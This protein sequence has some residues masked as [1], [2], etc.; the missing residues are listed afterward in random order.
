MFSMDFFCSAGVD[1]D[2]SRHTTTSVSTQAQRHGRHQV[3][4]DERARARSAGVERAGLIDAVLKGAERSRALSN[5]FNRWVTPNGRGRV[6]RAAHSRSQTTTA[7][8]RIRRHTPLARERSL[9][10][11]LIDQNLVH[12]MEEEIERQ[13]ARS[14]TRTHTHARAGR[15]G[16]E[17]AAAAAAAAGGSLPYRLLRGNH[18]VLTVLVSQRVIVLHRTKSERERA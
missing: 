9:F 17:E 3:H 2:A 15:R 10:H 13:D 5:S 12:R 16:G 18:F 7:A 4:H 11:F 14:R 8:A 6:A 1:K